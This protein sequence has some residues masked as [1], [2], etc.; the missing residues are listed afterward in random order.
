LS[1]F[2]RPL[3]WGR[4]ALLI[5]LAVLL[6]INAAAFVQTLLSIGAYQAA[7]AAGTPGVPAGNLPILIGLAALPLVNVIG[8]VLLGLGRRI[9]YALLLLTLAIS[10][11]LHLV[12]G[13]PVENLALTIVGLAV[14]W[15]LLQTRWEEMRWV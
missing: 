8:V 9:G 12:I 10:F 6:T 7:V 14:L 3:T 1:A 2:K 5:A 13:L 15:F 4:L 11:A